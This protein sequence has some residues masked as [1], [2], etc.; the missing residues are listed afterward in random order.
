MLLPLTNCYSSLKRKLEEAE[1][2][3]EE[4]VVPL[5]ILSC[6]FILTSFKDGAPYFALMDLFLDY[7]LASCL[8]F[9]APMLIV[10]QSTDLAV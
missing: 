1:L 4:Q 8:V 9:C 5:H 2:Q 3:T 6:A 7:T 10:Y